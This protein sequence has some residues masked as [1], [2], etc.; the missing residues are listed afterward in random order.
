MSTLLDRNTQIAAR[1]DRAPPSV[2]EHIKDVLVRGK[3]ETL[4]AGRSAT[5]EPFAAL[6][7]STLASGR[8]G[9][10]GPLVPDGEASRLITGY[11]VTTTAEPTK[12]VVAAG[13]PG[14]DWVRYHATGTSRMARRDP[15]GFRA[16]DK[17]EAMRLWKESIFGR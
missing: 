10:G 11:V 6:R 8:R 14:L 5:G 13:W 15:T 3:R 16:E 12:I 9:A 7:P 4:L 17:A 1:I 2:L